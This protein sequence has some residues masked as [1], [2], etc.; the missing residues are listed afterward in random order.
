MLLPHD[1]PREEWLA[2]R[3]PGIGASEIAAVAGL[4]RWKG[5]W[6]VWSAKLDGREVEPTE[7]MEW[8][9]W[10]EGRIIDW[11]AR[12]TDRVVGNGGL[13]QHHEHPW[14]IATPDAVVLNHGNDPVATVDAKTGGW[15]GM[16]DWEDGAPVDYICQVTW[17]MLA[18][19]VREGYLV[20]TI[21]GKP[22]FERH[23][24]LD[25]EFATELM[26]AGAQFWELVEAR[27]PPVVD[28]SRLA[29]DWLDHHYAD[30]DPLKTV[31]LDDEAIADIVALVEVD[32]RLTALEDQRREL[33]NAIKARLADAE[34]GEYDG[35]PW[36]TW[37]TVERA[38][39]EV[40]PTTYRRFTVPKNIREEITHG[41]DG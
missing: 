2:A 18:V 24:D 31:T 3:L 19:G 33:E 17:Q 7:E 9:L 26:D 32:E 22:P 12:R 8:G 29:A 36:V 28:G 10:I 30:A 4:S 37:K 14:L 35:R 21:G 6:D 23:F 39:Y 5:P 16:A 13:F 1:A 27:T 15:R 25:D 40:G 34:G 38:G 20:A 41:D 11:W